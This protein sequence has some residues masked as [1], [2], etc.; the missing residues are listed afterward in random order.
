MTVENFAN[1]GLSI[2]PNAHFVVSGDSD[3][4]AIVAC[5]V[6]V[7][8]PASVARKHRLLHVLF[9]YFVFRAR[10]LKLRI[11]QLVA[12]LELPYNARFVGGARREKFTIET[13]LTLEDVVVLMC[14]QFLHRFIILSV[15]TLPNEA[16]SDSSA[17][18]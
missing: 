7:P 2:A 16:G 3:R 14:K 1:F 8:D 10:R 5:Y 15:L 18:N 4:E 13:K 12:C 11:L 6:T 9:Q 17:G